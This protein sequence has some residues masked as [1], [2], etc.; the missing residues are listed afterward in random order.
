MTVPNGSF[1]EQYAHTLADHAPGDWETLAAH[2]DKVASS[3]SS[4]RRRL[5]RSFGERFFGRC[6]DLGKL[7][8]DFQLSSATRGSVC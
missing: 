4:S 2:L 1:A 7:S 6:H 5:E 3:A 8:D